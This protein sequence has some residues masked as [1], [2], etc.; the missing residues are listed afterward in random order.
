[1]I[2]LEYIDLF[3][4]GQLLTL[5]EIN[6]ILDFSHLINFGF[7]NDIY[8]HLDQPYEKCVDS[9]WKNFHNFIQQIYYSRNL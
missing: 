8:L 1:M 7:N 9:S 3:F 4:G 5:V 6:V 2:P